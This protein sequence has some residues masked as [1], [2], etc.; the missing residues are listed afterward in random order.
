M[1]VEVAVM[2]AVTAAETDVET[3]AETDVRRLLQEV[4]LEWMLAGVVMSWR[5]RRHVKLMV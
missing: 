5:R 4:T 2:A 3:A 1:F